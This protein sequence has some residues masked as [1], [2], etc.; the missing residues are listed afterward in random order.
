[1]KKRAEVTSNG[2][3]EL[4]A[5]SDWNEFAVEE[6]S[7]NWTHI[8]ADGYDSRVTL[9]GVSITDIVSYIDSENTLYLVKK[10][11]I[12]KIINKYRT[13]I[14]LE[15]LYTF[16]KELGTGGVSISDYDPAVISVEIKDKRGIRTELSISAY[17]EKVQERVQGFLNQNGSSSE[18]EII[19]KGNKKLLKELQKIYTTTVYNTK[20][21]GTDQNDKI[22]GGKGNDTI[23]GGAGNDKLYGQ[24]GDNRFEFDETSGND[25]VYSGKGEDLL[26][27]EGIRKESISYLKSGNNLVL[28]YGAK[29]DFGKYKNSVTISNYLKNPG[30]STI[31]YFQTS[32]DSNKYQI[33]E[34]ALLRY[35]GKEEKTNKI[36]GSSIRDYIVGGT[37]KDVL[38]GG[39]GN[40]EIYGKAGNDKIYG[41]NGDDSLYGG[42]GNDTIYGGNGDDYIN[43]GK[44]NDRIY[45]GSGK[46]DIEFT[47]GDGCDY[48]YLD[49][50]GVMNL[51]ITGARVEDISYDKVGN[52]LEIRYSEEDK[53]TIVNY[54][55]MKQPEILSG[56]YLRVGDELIKY[57]EIV[58]DGDISDCGIYKYIGTDGISNLITTTNKKFAYVQT[59]RGNNTVIMNSAEGAVVCDSGDDTI[60]V[61]GAN[62]FVDAGEG[63]N[64]I[65][66]NKSSEIKSGAGNDRY[67]IKNLGIDAVIS[68]IGGSD[69]IVINEDYRKIRFVFDV[70]LD[71]DEMVTGTGGL[72]IVKDS[73]YKKLLSGK[74]VKGIEISEYFDGIESGAGSIEKIYAKD[75]WY[76]NELEILR[77]HQ[78]VGT[79]LSLNGYDSTGEVLSCGDKNAIKQM[80]EVFSNTADFWNSPV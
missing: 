42:E 51:H 54:F 30:K 27:I 1:M 74:E 61:N 4:C 71:E 28:G 32:E 21:T 58:V 37:K 72:Y 20:I 56:E 29:D 18:E 15:D 41:D 14:P 31:K 6:M 44:G 13:K 70:N 50:K 80:L 36:K 69:E 25:T 2:Y 12:T 35:E 17:I 16:R 5:N 76:M 75:G 26:Y 48:V 52:N 63:E 9:S 59:G 55:K 38:R 11:N 3:R 78:Q 60:Y 68:D 7:K 57:S 10:S 8:N 24:M 23:V 34:E 62:S 45:G 33:L 73:M 39:G 22:K 66:V 53:I 64:L 47:L 77:V 49:K 43:G 67:E 79:W 19:L 46:N 40:D 65:K